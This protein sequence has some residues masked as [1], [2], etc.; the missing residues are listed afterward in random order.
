MFLGFAQRPKSVPLS[1]RTHCGLQN[2]TEQISFHALIFN[3]GYNVYF[4]VLEGSSSLFSHRSRLSTQFRAIPPSL[5]HSESR[6]NIYLSITAMRVLLLGANGRTGSL[7]LAEALSRGY[8][9]TALIRRLDS[10]EPQ[11]NLS[12]VPGSPLSQADI[13]KAFA[14]AP[15]F[16]P[17]KAVIST[18][19]NGRTGDN[20]WSTPTAPA[21]LMV[22][23]VR[24]TLA[25][26]REYGVRK[27]VVL[28][29]IGVGSSRAHSGWFFN[30]V[31]DH[32]NLKIAF[33]DHNKVQSLLETEA[34]KDSELKWVD[35]RSTGLNNGNRK[36]VKEFGNEGKGAGWMC[37][38]KSV[39]GFLIDAVESSR[40]D[41]RTPVIS[42]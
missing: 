41:G 29:S 5:K 24:N 11:A 8:T 21:N 20:P 2:R 25:V 40:W 38:R 28:G 4:S 23:T 18:L 33:D 37:S 34:A 42:N 27:I 7:V 39:A 10:L 36:E 16:D 15:T 26:M 3:V 1:I 31:V 13:A 35:V 12:I 22:D 30:W 32:S 6:H 14:S 17:I 19:N 9:V